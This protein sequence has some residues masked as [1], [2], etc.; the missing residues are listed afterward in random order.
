MIESMSP[1]KRIFQLKPCNRCPEPAKSPKPKYIPDELIIRLNDDVV[2][3]NGYTT[4]ILELLKYLKQG[5]AT[6]IKTLRFVA[7]ELCATVVPPTG[8]RQPV[9]KLG[10][11]V[12][13]FPLR[14]NLLEELTRLRVYFKKGMGQPTDAL[15]KC[16]RRF[17]GVAYA[18]QYPLVEF[19]P[20]PVETPTALAKNPSKPDTPDKPQGLASWHKGAVGYPPGNPNGDRIEL[21]VACIGVLDQF[22]PVVKNAPGN[23]PF[24]PDP[25]SLLSAPITW[26]ALQ[27]TGAGVHGERVAGTIF[28]FLPKADLAIWNIAP[29][30]YTDP[31]RLASAVEEILKMTTI[32]VVNYSRGSTTYSRTDAELMA[33]LSD[34]GVVVVASIGQTS[35]SANIK[36]NDLIAHFPAALETVI[37]V[38]GI[39]KETSA[40]GTGVSY[41]TWQ[42]SNDRYGDLTPTC[43]RKKTSPV[44]IVAPATDF[45]FGTLY[46]GTSYASPIVAALAGYIF[47]T[48][49]Q[50]T[51]ISPVDFAAEVRAAIVGV[52]DTSLTLAEP[53]SDIQ[54][55]Q[56]KGIANWTAT[57]KAIADWIA[58][59][60]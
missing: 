4:W 2:G 54:T 51:N 39:K 18:E 1:F 5:G 31:T 14:S 57:D 17:P 35:K 49:G 38:G 16:V 36:P 15:V 20:V 52:A 8:A 56:G 21:A 22:R 40:D 9:I 43:A 41:V 27:G 45:T 42:Q 50:N 6:E 24:P 30:G 46:T 28:D 37:G 25:L 33:Q 3:S 23:T 19:P 55:A 26:T 58:Q 10:N 11:E 12:Q 44:D 47:E 13:P 29:G 32:K 48:Y 7:R 60:Q 53:H 34:A 59:S